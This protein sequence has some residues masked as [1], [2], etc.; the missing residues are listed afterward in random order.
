M[1][2]RL[3]SL[4]ARSLITSAVALA[5]CACGGGKPEVTSFVPEQIAPAYLRPAASGKIQHVVIVIQENRSFNNLFYGYP[6]A[7][8]EKYGYDS[9]GRRIKLQPLTLKTSWDIA[10]DSNAFFAACNGTGTIPGTHCRMNGF[11]KEYFSCGNSCPIKYPPYSYVPRSQ[12]KPYF[13]M[14]QQYVLADRMYSSNFDASSFVSH[15]YIIAAQAEKSVNFPYG[16]WG[17]SGGPSDTI[18]EVGPQRQIPDGYEQACWDPPTLGDELDEA[19]ISWAYYAIAYYKV[20]SGWN[21]YQVI[22]HIY[23]GPDWSKD[24]FT[25]P[26]Q[27]LTD[28]KHGKMRTVTWVTPTCANSDHAGCYSDTGPSWVASV[29]NAIGESKY[30]GSTAIFVFWDDYGG[31]YDREGPAYVD[32]DGLGFRLPLLVISPYAKKGY[33]SH[34]HYEHGSILK[35]I[36]DQFGLKRLSKSDRRANSPEGDCFDFNQPPRKFKKILAPYGTQFFL[37]QPP[38]DRIPD[39]D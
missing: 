16:D 10:H 20:W 33:V 17:C 13:E 4:V 2:V 24:M 12:T 21:G 3:S 15:Q 25:P 36:E 6:G 7:K 38:D 26:S 30:W 22:R 1:L 5:V 18:A 19:G 29:V 34:V 28:V 37:H 31:W 9:Q 23:F 8:T 35:F 11:N 32:Y 39:A 27:F 14:A